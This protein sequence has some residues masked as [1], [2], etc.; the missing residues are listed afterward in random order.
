MSP[1]ALVALLAAGLTAQEPPVPEPEGAPPAPASLLGIARAYRDAIEGATR[2]EKELD[3]LQV[4]LVVFPD[5]RRWL[6]LR[7]L[8]E[9][10]EKEESL[11]SVKQRLE[12]TKKRLRSAAGRPGFHLEL[13][14]ESAPEETDRTVPRSMHLFPGDPAALL[15]ATYGESAADWSPLEPPKGMARARVRIAKHFTTKNRRTVPFIKEMEPK[16]ERWVFEGERATIVG[17]LPETLAEKSGGTLA[18]RIAGFDRFRGPSPEPNLLDLNAEESTFEREQQLALERSWP[19][20][21]P[22]LPP[23]LGELLGDGGS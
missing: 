6:L 1:L 7:D 23:E 19:P 10:L 12:G 11:E 14:H 3:D 21:W 20:P 5:A 15:R 9:G 16:G 18:F 13:R 8:I 4:R 17:M 22:P 2:V